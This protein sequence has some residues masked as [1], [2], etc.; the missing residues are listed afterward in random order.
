MAN[1]SVLLLAL[2]ATASAFVARPLPLRPTT[3]PCRSNPAP[4]ALLDPSTISLLAEITDLDGERAYGA[5]DAPG[6]VLPVFATLAIATSLLPILLT[7]GEEAFNRQQKDEEAT[8]GIFGRRE[9]L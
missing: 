2:C 1:L 3:V 8:K 5:V 9:K 7:P 4:V 6:W